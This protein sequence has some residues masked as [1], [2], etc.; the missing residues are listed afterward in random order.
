MPRTPEQVAADK[1]LSEAVQRSLSADPGMWPDSVM[2][3]FALVAH[4]STFDG[5]GDPVDG[6]FILTGAER[7][8]SHRVVGLLRLGESMERSKDDAPEPE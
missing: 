8:A 7:T 5:D 1:A 2:V 6:Y 3:E 4:V